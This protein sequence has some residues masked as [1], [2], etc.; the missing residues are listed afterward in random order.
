MAQKV[1]VPMRYE[2]DRYFGRPSCP[3]CGELLMAPEYSEF[4]SNHDIR[5]SWFCDGCDYRF[6]TLVAFEAAAA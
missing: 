1:A 2:H 6:E 3:K 5:H 4:R